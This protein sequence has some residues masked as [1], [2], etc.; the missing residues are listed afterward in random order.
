VT[1]TT[2]TFNGSRRGFAGA[3]PT[4]RG[5]SGRWPAGHGDRHR[6]VHDGFVLPAAFTDWDSMT[7]AVG[8]ATRHDVGKTT[9]KRDQPR[10]GNP[11]AEGLNNELRIA[12]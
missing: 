12:L 10:E 5:L 2:I 6:P 8:L 11:Q 4:R 1:K 7:A 3:L 9:V